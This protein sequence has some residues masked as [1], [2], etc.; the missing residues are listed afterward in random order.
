[1]PEGCAPRNRGFQLYFNSYTILIL[2]VFSL[3]ME[4]QRVM[5]QLARLNEGNLSSEEQSQFLDSHE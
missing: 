4:A 5:V 3:V 2:C 1:M